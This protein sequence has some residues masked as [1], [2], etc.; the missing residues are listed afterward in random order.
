MHDHLLL[1]LTKPAPSIRVRV[2]VVGYR[3]VTKPSDE[4]NYI[5]VFGCVNKYQH[6]PIQFI[7]VLCCSGGGP[8]KQG[9]IEL[10]RRV[11]VPAK[12]PI[13]PCHTGR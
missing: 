3:W 5:P 9:E 1:A 10:R 7:T 13:V 4:T 2:A 8:I 12:V 11:Q 6:N